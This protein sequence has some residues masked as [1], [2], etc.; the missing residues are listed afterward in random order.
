MVNVF[1]TCQFV[2]VCRCFG[3]ER[4]QE[5][6]SFVCHDLSVWPRPYIEL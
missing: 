3:M 4:N 2:D 5:F 6:H 1:F